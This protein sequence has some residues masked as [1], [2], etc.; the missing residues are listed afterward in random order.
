M[1]SEGSSSISRR[2]ALMRA[3]PT[4]T[5]CCWPPDSARTSWRAAVA[6]HGEERVDALEALRLHRA[7]ARRRRRRSSRFSAT[8]ML[9]KSRRPS[10]TR[11]R[12]RSTIW[13]APSTPRSSPSQRDG[14]G[15]RTYGRPAMDL[16]SD[17]LARAVGAEQRDDLAGADRERDAAERAQVAVGRLE[18]ADLKHGA[19]PRL[20]AQVGVEHGGIGGHRAPARPRRSSRPRSAR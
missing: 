9:P 5:I 3:R 16:S 17:A 7:R 18:V 1:P 11:A 20:A 15:A 14:A 4:A 13:C 6:Q 19:S 12:P 10:G 8:V 2:G